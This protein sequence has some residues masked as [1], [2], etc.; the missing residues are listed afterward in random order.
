MFV[1]HLLSGLLGEFASEKTPVLIQLIC[2][3]SYRLG[4]E[5]RKSLL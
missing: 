2:G 4:G 3:P 1:E 5:S